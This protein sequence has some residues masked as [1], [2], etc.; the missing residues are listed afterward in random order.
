M[1]KSAERMRT[2][3]KYKVRSSNVKGKGVAG[4][5]PVKVTG[6]LTGDAGTSE[7]PIFEFLE[8]HNNLT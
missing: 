3:V 5:S 8:H 4:A 2:K 7:F 1:V 6:W